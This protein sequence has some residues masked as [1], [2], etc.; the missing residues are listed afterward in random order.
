MATKKEI[1]LVQDL[2][3]AAKHALEGMTP[4]ERKVSPTWKYG[5]RY[6]AL[7]KQAI[8]AALEVRNDRWPPAVEEAGGYTGMAAT[9]YVELLTYYEQIW[10]IL[11]YAIGLDGEGAA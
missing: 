4:D 7:L 11:E 1:L 3:K 2:V 10:A 9:K 5:Q 8:E 6:N